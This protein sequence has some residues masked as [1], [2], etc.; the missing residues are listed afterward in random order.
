MWSPFA[1]RPRASSGKARGARR[2]RHPG[3]SRLS[4]EFLEDRCLPT[5]N[6]G[7]LKTELPQLLNPLQS[8]VTQKVLADSMPLVGSGLQN[9]NS[10]KFLTPIATNLGN[11]L[12]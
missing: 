3:A 8:A 5:V 6:Y 7:L 9:N 2:A 1:R 4:V 10:A 11:A 12:P